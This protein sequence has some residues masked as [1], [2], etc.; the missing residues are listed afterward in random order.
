MVGNLLGNVGRRRRV[1]TRNRDES[2]GGLT[3]RLRAG[4]ATTQSRGSCPR[5]FGTPIHSTLF[6]DLRPSFALCGGLRAVRRDMLVRPMVVRRP[7]E[8]RTTKAPERG[9]FDAR[10]EF[11]HLLESPTL[12]ADWHRFFAANPFVLSMALP[13]RL[14]PDDVVPLGRPGRTEPDFVLFPQDT[15]PIPY[16]G[17]VELKKPTSEIV[18]IPRANVAIL[19]RDAETAIQQACR[20]CEDKQL[21]LPA[22]L[23]EAP[24]ILGN[25]EHMFIVMRMSREVGSKLATSVYRDMIQKR[26]PSNLQLIPYDSL[27]KSFESQLP[28]RVHFLTP[29][30]T[31]TPGVERAT[32]TKTA[33]EALAARL[34][35]PDR[36]VR[37]YIM[38]VTTDN[39]RRRVDSAT[40]INMHRDPDL[41]TRN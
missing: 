29:S 32:L 27:L 33:L 7:A 36:S 5:P 31:I 22:L 25:R 38:M 17:V 18:R 1:S 19:S 3:G 15:K 39:R 9:L 26:L 13:L 37:A 10:D 21:Y 8:R 24:F 23:D 34:S 12:E 20:Y 11:R 16:Y 6:D 4:Y 40:A 30:Q 28:A 14:A 35:S 41:E 2:R